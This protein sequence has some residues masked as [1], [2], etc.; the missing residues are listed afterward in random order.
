MSNVYVSEHS[1]PMLPGC[2]RSSLVLAF[3][4]HWLRLTGGKRFYFYR[5]VSGRPL[6]D[7]SFDYSSNRQQ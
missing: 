7:G 3:D 2:K 4:G 1:Y 5:A 6:P